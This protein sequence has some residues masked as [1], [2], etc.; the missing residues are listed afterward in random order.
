MKG[1]VISCATGDSTDEIAEE[2]EAESKNFV[3]LSIKFVTNMEKNSDVDPDMD[4][5][6]DSED[7]FFTKVEIIVE[8]ND[9]VMVGVVVFIEILF[10]KVE[11]EV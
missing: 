4:S 3:E 5:D 2:R 9:P 10:A 11:A 8:T 1:V 6:V 7:K